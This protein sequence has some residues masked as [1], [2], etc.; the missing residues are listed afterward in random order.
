[1]NKRFNG[2]GVDAGLIMICDESYYEKYNYTKDK[3]ISK[4]FE[5]T[6]GK[7][8]CKW[9]IP[10][11]W[12]GNVSGDGILNVTSGVVIVSDPCYC[13]GGFD[14]GFKDDG[15]DRWLKDTNFV[16]DVLEGVILIDKTGGDGT[17]TVYLDLSKIEENKE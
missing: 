9:R 2:V 8:N 10:N 16:D 13:I 15:W 5:I 1:M 14:D 11:T 7:Y 3:R 4:S 12:N 6:P 17:Y